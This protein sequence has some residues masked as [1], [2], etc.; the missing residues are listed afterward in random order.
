MKRKRANNRELTKNIAKQPVDVVFVVH[1]DEHP[2]PAQMFQVFIFD[3]QIKI[4]SRIVLSK[5]DQIRPERV[6]QIR[7]TAPIQMSTKWPDN[8]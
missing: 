2:F 5:S 1:D 8:H 4:R 3:V 7:N 6:T